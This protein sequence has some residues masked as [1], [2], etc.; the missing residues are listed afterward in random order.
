MTRIW[1][2]ISSL[3]TILKGLEKRLEELEI[4]GRIETIQMTALLSPVR[5]LRRILETWEDLLSLNIKWKTLKEYERCYRQ[6]V[7]WREGGRWLASIEDGV[8]ALM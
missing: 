7:S 8:D 2:V 1:I 4:R 6:Y 3:G 5:I